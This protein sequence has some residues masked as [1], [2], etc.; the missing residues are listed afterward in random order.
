MVELLTNGVS[1][2]YRFEFSSSAL[3][4]PEISLWNH[5]EMNTFDS[6]GYGF[7]TYGNY[8]GYYG[9]DYEGFVIQ[10]VSFHISEIVTTH[11]SDCCVC[12]SQIMD[13]D[14]AKPCLSKDRW[15][16]IQQRRQADENQ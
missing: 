8:Q 16:K 12:M 9:I 3:S 14:S 4:G 11:Q 5:T 6:D 13:T 1:D 2:S 7:H 15:N 10:S